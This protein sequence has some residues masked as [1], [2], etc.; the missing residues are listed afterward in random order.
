MVGYTSMGMV[1]YKFVNRAHETNAK[2]G[3]GV[4]QL[5]I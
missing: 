1:I 4:S 3:K 2:K 5:M